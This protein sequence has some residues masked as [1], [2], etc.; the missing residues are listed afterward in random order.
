MKP[1]KEVA[2]ENTDDNQNLL[3]GSENDLLQ[4]HIVKLN[5]YEPGSGFHVLINLNEDFT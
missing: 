4:V 2:F 5:Y 3:D 1:A